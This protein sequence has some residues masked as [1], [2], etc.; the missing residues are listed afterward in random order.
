MCRFITQHNATDVA[1]FEEACRHACWLQECPPELSMEPSFPCHKLSPKASQPKIACNGA[2]PGPP[3]AAPSPP[4]W[5]ETRRPPRDHPDDRCNKRLQNHWISALI[6]GR[7]GTLE[8]F[9][10]QLI[11]AYTTAWSRSCPYPE[12]TLVKCCTVWDEWW[13]PQTRTV[14]PLF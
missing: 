4:R 14:F 9:S 5:S 7:L 3:H 1:S 8:R 6:R 12:T 13:S 10:F 11:R 2:S